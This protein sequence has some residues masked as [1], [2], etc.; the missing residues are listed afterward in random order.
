[1][2]L[3]RE[4]LTTNVVY[5]EA[6]ALQ[7]CRSMLLNNFNNHVPA[8][9][10]LAELPPLERHYMV[11][12]A[13][14]TTDVTGVQFFDE[15]NVLCEMNS[16]GEEVVAK[17]TGDDEERVLFLEMRG[18]ITRSG[19]MCSYGSQDMRDILIHCADDDTVVGM[20]L[21]TDTPGGS[22]FSMYDFQQ[23][24]E[25]WNKSGKR[26]IQFI[27]G[28][29]CS[30]GVALGVQCQKAIAFNAH[31][32]IGCIGAMSSG[33]G[34]PNGTVDQNGVRSFN[35]VST[36]SPDKN[37]NVLQ[38]IDGKYDGVQ[39]STDEWYDRLNEVIEAC[40]PQIPAEQRTGKTYEARE[41]IGTF[42]DGLG[43][44]DDAINY[45]LTGHEAWAETDK[46]E[47]TTENTQTQTMK[48]MNVFEKIAA[49]FGLKAEEVEAAAEGGQQEETA[50]AEIE[51]VAEEAQQEEDVVATEDLLA[52]IHSQTD[53]I[54][55]MREKIDAMA[56]PAE[57]SAE[58]EQLTEQVAQY[59]RKVTELL[60]AKEEAEQKAETM[61]AELAAVKAELEELR[62]TA[63]A[64]QMPAPSPRNQ[65]KPGHPRMMT[66]EMSAQE[67]YNIWKE[68]N[69]KK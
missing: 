49:T 54:E 24:M 14:G 3:L 56:K 39:A 7:R 45:C 58:V 35:V 68:R 64:A 26:S 4:L 57:P 25:A 28:E 40:R 9:T 42:I 29:S 13:K 33:F 51:T 36:Q 66:R 16:D 34:A 59:D 22:C 5:M 65:E 69:K 31:D 30:C 15:D 48:P 37:A 44:L 46:P 62:T 67:M 6:G 55:A 17:E 19:G 23:G 12:Y 38:A 32:I 10:V 53:L 18:P 27:D 8:E 50:P 63:P 2:K 20:V 11:K 61:A 52:L 41:V 43:T 1:M 47:T 60:A 21:V